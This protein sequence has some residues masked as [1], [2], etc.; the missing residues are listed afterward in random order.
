MNSAGT[1]NIRPEEAPFTAEATVWLMLFS[2][3]LVR[4][5]IPRRIAQPRIAASSEP[6]MLK[7]SLRL[8]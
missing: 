1:V 4:R 2:M 6:S 8:A 7:P 3:M 5:I